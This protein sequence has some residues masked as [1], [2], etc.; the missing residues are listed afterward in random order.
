MSNLIKQTLEVLELK[1]TSNIFTEAASKPSLGKLAADHYH[2]HS[3]HL[4]GSEAGRSDKQIE[5]HGEKKKKIHATIT[6]HYGKDTAD[7]VHKHS[8]D[9]A[10]VENSSVGHVKPKFHSDFVSKH[11]GGKDSKQHQDYKKQITHHGEDEIAAHQTEKD[12][13]EHA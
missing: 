1:E 9:A 8:D 2:H 3:L 10:T 7:A 13:N 4:W 6:H 12:W 5:A 11:L